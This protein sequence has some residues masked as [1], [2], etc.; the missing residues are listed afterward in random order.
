MR[1]FADKR[2]RGTRCKDKGVSYCAALPMLKHVKQW[3][4][5][6]S[7]GVTDPEEGVE[8]TRIWLAENTWGFL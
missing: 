2:R 4:L 6:V 1:E 8:S 7:V 5:V 3:K